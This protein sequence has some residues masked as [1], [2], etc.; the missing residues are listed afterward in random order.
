MDVL[1]LSYANN[2]LPER[3]RSSLKGACIA[4]FFLLVLISYFRFDH[5]YP[6]TTEL[7]LFL[8]FLLS[9]C[10][11]F[12]VRSAY[13]R[14]HNTI[15]WIQQRIF[16]IF[17]YHGNHGRVFARKILF[18][19]FQEW[20]CRGRLTR[21]WQ[22]FSFLGLV[23]FFFFSSVLICSV[24]FYIAPVDCSRVSLFLYTD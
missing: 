8:L 3:H 14:N 6:D 15:C 5:S 18:L 12:P 2:L 20:H 10:P 21:I 9:P 1:V 7:L 4:P 17:G 22:L 16:L 11:A 19:V 23:C 24:S 13:G